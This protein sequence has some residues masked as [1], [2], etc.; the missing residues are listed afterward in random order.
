MWEGEGGWPYDD[1][2]KN[3]F[4]AQNE[5]IVKQKTNNEAYNMF[6]ISDVSLI[7]INVNNC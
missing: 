7:Y 2:S 3:I 6:F 1:I 4:F 5:I